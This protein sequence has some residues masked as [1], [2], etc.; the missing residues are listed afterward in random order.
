MNGVKL[1]CNQVFI[2]SEERPLGR[3]SIWVMLSV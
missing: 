1:T 2:S 3:T